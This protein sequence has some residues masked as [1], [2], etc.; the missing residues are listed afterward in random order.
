MPRPTYTYGCE[1]EMFTGS[2]TRMVDTAVT[3]F[4]EAGLTAHDHLHEYHCGCTMCR[5]NRTTPNSLLAAQNDPTVGV[6]FIT[7][8]MKTRSN[9]DN[10]Q[11]RALK[12]TY[13]EV[14]DATG[15][16]PDG[17][18]NAGNHIHVGWP[19]STTDRQRAQ[20]HS[21][22]NGMFRA[23]HDLW[24]ETIAT[25]GAPRVRSYNRAPVISFGDWSGGWLGANTGTI[26][27]RVWNTPVDP[28][29]LLVHP[30]LSVALVHWGLEIRDEEGDIVAFNRA[31]TAAEWSALRARPSRKRIAKIVQ[32]VWSDRVSARHAAELIAA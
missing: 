13:S 24:T 29:R 8:I 26:E 6:E 14:L 28:D 1:I 2:A 25:G 17:H 21:L 32:D 27:V 16:R 3:L 9:A 30:A 23:E 12:Q 22:L 18:V 15:W 5:Y 31:E 20:V 4:G 19:D 7:K 11:M 10:Q